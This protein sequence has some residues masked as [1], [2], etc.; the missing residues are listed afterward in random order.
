MVETELA[1]PEESPVDQRGASSD[2]AHAVGLRNL[3]LTGWMN[4]GLQCLHSIK[5][6]TYYFLG[7]TTYPYSRTH[8]LHLLTHLQSKAENHKS[9]LNTTNILGYSGEVASSYASL[10]E[11]LHGKNLNARTNTHYPSQFLATVKKYAPQFNAGRAQADA[12]EFIAWALD[13]LSEDLSRVKKRTYVEKPEFE[14]GMIG[15]DDA[16]EAFA[17]K[18]IAWERGRCDSIV[19][20]LCH[21]WLKSTLECPSCQN[22]SISFD[23]FSNLPVR[24]SREGTGRVPLEECFDKNFIESRVLEEHDGWYCKRCDKVQT[25]FLNTE[26]WDVSDYVIVHLKKFTR[27]EEKPF[28]P[29]SYPVKGLDLKPWV[30]GK[31]EKSLVFDLS[32][33]VHHR[34]AYPGRGYYKAFLKDFEKDV[35]MEYNGNLCFQWS[36]MM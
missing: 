15:N 31:S 21:G 25:A 6:L 26:I 30:R 2:E 11:H 33:V 9:D 14:E 27:P 12:Q 29:T 7:T 35:W 17:E 36:Q 5:E 18:C 1:R 4:T 8:S 3:G 20:D 34:Y 28:L 24:P 22:T 23:S 16:I 19:R 32:A 13:A 10:I